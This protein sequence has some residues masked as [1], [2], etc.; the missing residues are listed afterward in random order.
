MSTL[1]KGYFPFMNSDDEKTRQIESFLARREAWL[2]HVVNNEMLGVWPRLVGVSIALRMSKERPYAWPGQA[3]LARDLG[4][5]R[6]TVSRAIQAL[7][8]AGLLIK[9]NYKHGADAGKD[10]RQYTYRIRMPFDF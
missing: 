6:M 8:D 1:K 2:R 4:C 5:N 10:S 7:C 3:T 9:T